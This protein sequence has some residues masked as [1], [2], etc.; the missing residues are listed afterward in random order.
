MPDVLI[1]GLDEQTLKR[2]KAR[3]KRHG[4]SVQQE[5]RLLLE[6]AAGGGAEEIARM[7]DGW[8]KRF[9]GRKFSGSSAGLIRRDRGR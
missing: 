4:R 3:A 7:L 1:R 8:K 9:A 5:A 2:L 6:Q